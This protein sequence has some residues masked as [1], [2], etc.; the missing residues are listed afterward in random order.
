MQGK[1]YFAVYKICMKT[2]QKITE[3]QKHIEIPDLSKALVAN[4]GLHLR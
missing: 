1:Q 2:L 3:T 4:V